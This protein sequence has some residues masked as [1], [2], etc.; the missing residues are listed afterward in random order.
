MLP[1]R[2]NA[3]PAS[4]ARW[5]V[6]RNADRQHDHIGMQRRLILQQDINTAIPLSKPFHGM[7]QCKL[8]TVAAHFSMDQRCH[9]RIKWIHQLLGTL[10]NGDGNPKTTQVFRQFQADKPSAG[11]NRGFWLV[12]A[13]YA[14][15]RSV[16][17]T[18][19]SVNSLGMPM[20]GSRG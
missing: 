13:I 19:R 14:L 10:Y 7:A 6:R 2:P 18:V 4:C 16:S 1:F 8:Y 9:I 11:E 17:S 3:S 5:G 20:P 15:M 12:D